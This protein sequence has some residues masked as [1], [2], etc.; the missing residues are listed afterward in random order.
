MAQPQKAVTTRVGSFGNTQRQVA[1]R[2]TTSA[3]RGKD[4]SRVKN[5]SVCL[6]CEGAPMHKHKTAEGAPCFKVV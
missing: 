1:S 4:H 3:I 2:C 5:G 6:T